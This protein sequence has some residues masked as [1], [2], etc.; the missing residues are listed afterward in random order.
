MVGFNR[1][2]SPAAVWLKE[3][4]G[5]P[6]ADT[7]VHFTVNAGLVPAGSWIFDPRQGGGRVIGEMCH[8]VDLAQYLTG[9]LPAEV[10]GSSLVAGSYQP[11][12]NVAVTMRMDNGALVS[13]TYVAN[14][15][16]R[17]PRERVEVFSRGRVGTVENFTHATFTENGRRKKSRSSGA[18]RGHKGELAALID[19]IAKGG[20]QPVPTAD[21]VATTLAT[22]AI[23][24]SLRTGLPV[25]VSVDRFLGTERR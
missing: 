10:H 19:A 1:R 13:I 6:D 12:D 4:L 5:E 14:G 8:F 16:R 9:A 3:R 25:G 18:D 11:S 2:F 15:D 23:E 22:F 21:Y 7:V 24:E 20:L 17:Y